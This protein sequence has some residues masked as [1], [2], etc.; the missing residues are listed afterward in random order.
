[1]L[2][3]SD[4]NSKTSHWSFF[5]KIRRWHWVVFVVR[6]KVVCIEK[7]G[8]RSDE[9]RKWGRPRTSEREGE[10]EAS[11]VYFVA[12]MSEKCWSIFFPSSADLQSLKIFLR[13][14]HKFELAECKKKISATEIPFFKKHQKLFFDEDTSLDWSQLE[15][16]L[17]SQFGRQV[18][19]EFKTNTNCF[20]LLFA[21]AL[22][23]YTN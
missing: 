19:K 7:N 6:V 5:I 14:G 20:F 10:R 21:P 15:H 16:R 9:E 11:C 2:R 17:E 12:G 8:E 18:L 3:K 4:N 1:M 13:M 23:I 22:Y